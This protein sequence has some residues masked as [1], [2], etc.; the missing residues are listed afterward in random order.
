LSHIIFF[1]N[2]EHFLWKHMED[3]SNFIISWLK[4]E[5][6][7]NLLSLLLITQ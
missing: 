5:I 1:F 7:F 4:G 3:K 6:I 2:I